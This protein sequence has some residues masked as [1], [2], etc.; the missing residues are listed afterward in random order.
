M[1]KTSIRAAVRD[2]VRADHKARDSVVVQATTLLPD[3]SGLAGVK[4]LDSFVNLAQKLGVGAD[5]SLSTASYGYNP[6][7][8]NR[9]LLE[10]IHRGSWLGGVAIDV[11]ADDM[12]RAGIEYKGELAPADTQSIDE[13]ITRL[14]IWPAAN[15]TVKWARLYGGAAA[16]ML[17]DGQDMRTPLDM[18]TIGPNQFKGL[19]VLDRWMIEPS[20]EDLV[21]DLGPNL[22]LPK[23]YRVGANAPA[24]RNTA[25]HY[26]RLAFRMVG[27]QLPYQQRLT[28]MLWGLSVIERLYDRMI[29]YDTAS[30][31]VAQLVGKAYLRTMK[32]KGMREV[33][34]SGG[35][36][37]N[38]LIAYTELM[39][40]YQGIEGI[41]LI[42][43]EDEFEAD[44]HGA[45]SGLDSALS[46]LAQQLSGALQIPLTRLF[47]QSPGGLNAS[48]DNEMRQ[49]YEHIEQKQKTDLHQG[50]TRVYR[51]VAQSDGIVLP[52]DFGLSFRPLWQLTDT[53]KA[54]IAKTVTETVL[55]A[56]E[57]ALISDQ[58]AL[59]ELREVARTTGVWSN[60]TA[61][62]IALA[63]A[64]VADPMEGMIDPDTGLPVDAKGDPKAP[65]FGGDPA[66]A[67]GGDGNGKDEG[68]QKAP[69]APGAAGPQGKAPGVAPRKVERKT[70]PGPFGKGG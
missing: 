28:E 29:G 3:G 10:W 9:T 47:G 1:A 61:E 14:A 11:V 52:D 60:I 13:T 20:T 21:T 62:D 55:S 36:A 50:L 24:L 23:Y 4:T 64:E 7:T 12:T 59:K 65:P 38:G 34:S 41:T 54:T 19:L 18:R 37:L 68:K 67:G 46:Q 2:A 42:D 63:D 32:I 58:T 15:E 6:I 49:Y 56:K 48:G 69:G 53:E 45:F 25:I 17:I 57:A 44:A 43:G 8:K 40:R 66:A 35:P 16:V 5:N 30:A 70:V 26:T 27:I 33:V 51:A 22:G 39:R 31:G